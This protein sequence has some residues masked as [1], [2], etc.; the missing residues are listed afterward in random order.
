MNNYFDYEHL[1]FWVFWVDLLINS[2]WIPYGLPN[3]SYIVL[4]SKS[5]VEKNIRVVLTGMAI[6]IIVVKK[7]E[8]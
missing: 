4:P 5:L 7:S 6:Y 2:I 1:P 3:T 8:I